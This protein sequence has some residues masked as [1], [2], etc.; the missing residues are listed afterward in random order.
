MSTPRPKAPSQAY[1]RFV[2]L[3]NA[4][5]GLPGIP[6]L[7]AM[8]ERVLNALAA[9]WAT[10]R[11]LPV[12]EAMRFGVESSPS[13]VHRRLKGLQ[14]KGLIELRAGSDDSRVR[15]IVPTGLAM[16]YFERLGR[17]LDQAVKGEHPAAER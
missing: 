15:L 14:R 11:D 5:R 12:T 6:V 2:N 1:L 16:G 7:D 10:G 17:C 13:T 9:V 4:I 3:T 8:E